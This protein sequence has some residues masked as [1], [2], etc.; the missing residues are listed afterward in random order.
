VTLRV[1]N[2]RWAGI[3]FRLR[4]GKA[5]SGER[6]E[7]ALHFRPIPHHPFDDRSTPDVLRFSLEPDRIALEINLNGAGDPFDLERA[8]LA[9]TFPQ[10]QLPP[11][12]LLLREIMGRDPTLSIRGDEAEESWRI[13]EP[14]VE[15]WATDEV[16]LLEYRAGSSG[17]PALAGP[18]AGV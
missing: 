8:T 11:Y 14:I 2:W 15:A 17:P 1:Q 9:A 12:S 10:Q 6:R 3:P 13:V 7:I 18:P 16:P 5:L 4:T